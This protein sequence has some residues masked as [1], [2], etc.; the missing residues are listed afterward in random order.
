[1]IPHVI[2]FCWFGGKEKPKE[3]LNYIET[4]KKIFP[5]YEIVE[6]N[7]NNYDINACD[8]IKEAYERGKWAF[9]SDYVRLD[10]LYK[11]G[12]IYLDTD[13]EARKR[14]D[15]LLDKYKLILGFEDDKYVMTGFMAAEREQV[16]FKKLLQLYNKK[17]FVKDNGK[18]DVVPNPVIVTSIMKKYGLM[19][20]GKMQVFGD[21]YIV[22]PNDFFCA[23]NNTFQR[24]KVTENTYLV[25]HCMG[26][27]QTT[28]D[29]LK[30]F[31]KC[32]IVKTF[33]INAFETFKGFF[34]IKW[35]K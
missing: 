16:C 24:I 18:I 26:S 12:G 30:P 7:E 17:K 1:M 11:Y 13:I 29:K 19:P 22:F 23:Y 14:F 32:I 25:H 21:N 33:G 8:Y 15:V 3:I 27:W 10:V 31:L 35:G 6:W 20:D 28:K 4:W 9:V 2:H 34:Y 5:D